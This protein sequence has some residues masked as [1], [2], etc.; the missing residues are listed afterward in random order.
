MR[1]IVAT[2]LRKNAVVWSRRYLKLDNAIPRAVQL[3]MQEGQPRDVIEF[4]HVD[5]GMQI[6]T[7]KLSV[8]NKLVSNW[9]WD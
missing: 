7:V 8:G 2:L 4:S 3:A 5:T 1:P 6:G 9:V